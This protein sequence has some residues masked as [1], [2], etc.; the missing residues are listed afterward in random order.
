MT[1][2]IA[3]VGS[4]H[5]GD[6][7]RAC[8][9]VDTAAAIGCDGVKF[10]L[11]RVDRLFA[12]EALAEKPELNDRRQL[13]LPEEWLPDL[14]LRAHR[15]G[16]L[17]G[18]TPFDLGAVSVLRGLV[19][20][21]DFLKVSS[22]SLLDTRL[23][24][25]C[26]AATASLGKL[27][28]V[29]TGMAT[30]SELS[31]AWL[32]ERRPTIAVMHCVSKYPTPARECNLSRIGHLRS[33]LGARVGYSDHSASPAVLLRAV[34]KWEA[35]YVECH[36]DLEDKAGAEW[37]DGHCW[38]PG[39]LEDVIQTV[40]LGADADCSTRADGQERLWR[41]DPSDGLRPLLSHRAALRAALL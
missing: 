38:T 31:D 20:S 25:A 35:A 11:F 19:P 21:V 26:A 36:L 6:Y 15:N 37:A 9:L 39:A 1:Q 33:L 22:Y 27:L 4:N 32:D 23:L 17:F 24:H 34:L 3:E 29:S 7:G 41:A 14:C 13:E 16:L 5:N 18:C 28:M 40:R 30:S 8:E 12:T 10:Q 2:F